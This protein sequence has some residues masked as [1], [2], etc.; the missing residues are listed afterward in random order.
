MY[1]YMVGLQEMVYYA[2]HKV[3]HPISSVYNSKCSLAHMHMPMYE[4]Q[5][6]LQNEPIAIHILW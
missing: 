3:Y 1:A 4:Q 2:T 6:Q 5:K